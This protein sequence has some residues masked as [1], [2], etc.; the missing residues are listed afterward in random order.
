MQSTTNPTPAWN[1]WRKLVS[2]TGALRSDNS[3]SERTERAQVQHQVIDDRSDTGTNTMEQDTGTTTTAPDKD[4][5]MLMEQEAVQEPLV[6][7]G[8]LRMDQLCEWARPHSN[9]QNTTP[10]GSPTLDTTP[11]F[12]PTAFADVQANLE[13]E[14]SADNDN[15]NRTVRHTKEIRDEQNKEQEVSIPHTPPCSNKGL[16]DVPT[17][18]QRFWDKFQQEMHLFANESVELP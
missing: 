2:L 18:P 8:A 3:L 7:T 14:E 5:A 9:P 12:F 17:T 1:N 10:Q 15:T 16:P 4:A 13:D 6:S 11:C